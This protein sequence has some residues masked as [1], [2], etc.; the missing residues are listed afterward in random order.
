MTLLHDSSVRQ[1][2]ETRLRA[3]R[4]DTTP[5]WGK[6]SADQ[7][8]WHLNRAL[9]AALGQLP[10]D[11]EK[12]PLPAPIMKFIVLKLPWPKGAPTNPSFVPKA[13]YDFESER[14]HCLR[15][16]ETFTARSLNSKWQDHPFFGPMTGTELSRLQA[17][18]FNHHLTQFG[19]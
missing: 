16:L 19:V 3:L 11:P 8:V 13:T 5:R 18:H 1:S 4:A 7:M 6:M 12:P 15:L 2:I 14:A 17:K 10:V 9:E